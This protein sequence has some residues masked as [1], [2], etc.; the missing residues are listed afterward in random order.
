M[1]RTIYIYGLFDGCECR[2]VGA[3]CNPVD[4]L[5][6]HKDWLRSLALA[7]FER[8]TDR[9][10]GAREAHYIALYKERGDRLANKYMSAGYPVATVPTLPLKIY[11]LTELAESV[12]ITANCLRQW[13]FQRRYDIPEPDERLAAG[14]VWLADGPIDAWITKQRA[15]YSTCSTSKRSEFH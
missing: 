12:G 15:E 13:L 7:Y 10:A 2:Y 6:T 4:R 9:E 1:S 14:A 11:G 3:S 5:R 8:V